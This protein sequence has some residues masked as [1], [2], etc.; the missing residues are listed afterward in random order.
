MIDAYIP[1]VNNFLN[2]LQNTSG[3]I[4]AD[5]IDA[6]MKTLTDVYV[7]ILEK[8]LLVINA[9]NVP[10]KNELTKKFFCLA[11]GLIREGM[12]PDTAALF[13]EYLLMQTSREQDIPSN[14][15]FEIYLL[16]KMMPVLLSDAE[17]IKK[18]V[19]F[20]IE[21]CSGKTQHFQLIKFI[22]ILDLYKITDCYTLN[23]IRERLKL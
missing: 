8:G 23:D 18:Y 13:L 2:N 4:N 20:I 6:F 16:A 11:F 15:L 7:T 14:V 1:A 5:D 12:I 22:K 17:H 19:D 21:F 3:K 9:D 10:F